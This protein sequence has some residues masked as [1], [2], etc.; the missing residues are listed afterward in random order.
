MKIYISGTPEIS[1]FLVSNV[2]E[3]LNRNQGEL[4]FLIHDNIKKEQFNI[5]CP[6]IENLDCNNV[7]TFEQLFSLCQG[8][9]LIN[10]EIKS[11]DYIVL[12]TSLKNDKNWFSASIKKNTFI[13]INDWEEITNSDPK[14]GITYQVLEN[15]FQLLIG[16]NY[17]NAINHSNVHHTDEFCINEMCINKSKVIVKLKSADICDSCLRL[18]SEMKVKNE[19]IKE[20][21]LQI[22]YIRQNLIARVLCNPVELERVN[23]DKAGIITI[24]SNVLESQD[25]PKTLFVFFLK[26]LNGVKPLEFFKHIDLLFDIYSKYKKN[27]VKSKI[28]GLVIPKT[29]GDKFAH[30]YKQRYQLTRDLSTTINS[31]ILDHYTI[32]QEKE[33]RLYKINLD[34]SYI[35]IHKGF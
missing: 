25:I 3:L 15:I 18:A 20:I 32:N 21:L 23:I 22:N 4:K 17:S 35:K 34:K 6:E 7:L 31:K 16:I 19:I 11:S 27:P 1:N 33:S 24:G 8:I 14:F 9:R 26:K 5:I 28:T 13:D 12:L 30:F 10:T 29:K 2:V